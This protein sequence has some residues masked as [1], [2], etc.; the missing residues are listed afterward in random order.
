MRYDRDW[1][2]DDALKDI[3]G[4]TMTSVVQ[5]GKEEIRFHCNDG[6]EYVMYH[7]Q[8]CCES[9]YIEDVCGNL[10]WLE[11]TP[12]TVSEESSNREDTY[13]TYSDGERHRDGSHTWTFYRIGTM[14]GT[15]VIR[16]YGSSNGYYSE[17]AEFIRL[18][19]ENEY[20]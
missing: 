12:I 15:V 10:E 14:N 19:K 16:W 9:V 4:K 3:M 17:S 6:T 8:D 11:N 2:V 1:D 18:P 5:V 13:Y 20:D 7:A